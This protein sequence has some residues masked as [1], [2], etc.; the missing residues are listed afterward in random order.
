MCE[1][2]GIL[3]SRCCQLELNIIRNFPQR[4]LHIMH[5]ESG[6]LLIPVAWRDTL[7]RSRI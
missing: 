1:L 7:D 4:A 5:S 2:Y 3:L 6:F